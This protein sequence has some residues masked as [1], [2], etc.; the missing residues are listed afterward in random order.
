M[1]VL[2]Y[3]QSKIVINMMMMMMIIIIIIIIIIISGNACYHFVQSL[4]SSSL[5]SKNLKIKIYRTIYN[6]AGCFI[7][8]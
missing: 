3:V 7:W 2:L 8:L 4:L 6:L 1:N 5:L